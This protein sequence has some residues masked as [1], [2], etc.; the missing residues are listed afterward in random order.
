MP[1][2][3]QGEPVMYTSGQARILPLTVSYHAKL[4]GPLLRPNLVCW[5][6][7]KLKP[8]SSARIIAPLTL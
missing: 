7:L 3:P 4:L 5:Q 6:E 8:S 2:Q 1:A